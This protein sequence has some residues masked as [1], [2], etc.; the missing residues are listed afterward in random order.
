MCPICKNCFVPKFTIYSEYSTQYL[1]EGREGLTMQLLS[2][3]VLY[4]ELINVLNKAGDIVFQSE[5]LLGEHSV[6]YWN[7]VLYFKIIKLPCFILDL[8]FN[9]KHVRVQASW[10][11]KYLPSQG[12]STTTSKQGTRSSFGSGK[13]DANGLKKL[14]Q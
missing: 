12:Y 4:K 1:K 5:D 10:I 6:V 7:L 8:D 9:P 11:M 3:V 2:P 13:L 14:E